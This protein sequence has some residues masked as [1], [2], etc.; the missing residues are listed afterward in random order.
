M[1]VITARKGHD[2]N[3]IRAIICSAAAVGSAVATAATG[4]A[5]PDTMLVCSAE[6]GVDVTHIDGR[7]GC[8]AAAED[9]LARAT[10]AGGVGYA[11]AARGASALGIGAAGGVGASQGFG[12]I[13]IAVGVG[14]DAMATSTVGDADG[15]GQVAVAIAFEGSRAEAGG[16]DDPAVCLGAGAFA[17][18]TTSGQ[19]CLATPFG[20][21][22]VA[23]P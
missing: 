18:S 7:T 16:P 20:K 14:Q 13:P 22:D 6:H 15:G 11:Y 10:G 21:W 19:S 9:G 2:M 23:A 4:S 1:V 8:R 5:N 3:L 12:G 17:W